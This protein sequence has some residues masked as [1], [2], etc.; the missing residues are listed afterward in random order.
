MNFTS[1]RGHLIN[2]EFPPSCKYWN[3]N[4]IS[5]LYHEDPIKFIKPEDLPI[6]KN[7][8]SLAKY[9]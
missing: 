3:I 7:L 4:K 9:F 5:N 2:Y 6:K 1:V 8:E